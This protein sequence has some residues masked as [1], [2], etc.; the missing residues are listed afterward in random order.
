MDAAG[1]PALN[2]AT[3][4]STVNRAMPAISGTPMLAP[5]AGD[6]QAA[7]NGAELLNRPSTL[8]GDTNSTTFEKLRNR[9]LVSA[10]I[11]QAGSSSLGAAA[12]GY[13]A[14]QYGPESIP[15]Y[16]R[17]PG[18]MLAGALMGQRAG[19]YLGRVVG[20]IPG[21]SAAITGPTE[22]IMRRVSAGLA[23]P[24]EYQRLLSSQMLTGP[25]LTTPGFI[26]A[27][28]PA[29]ARAAIPMA[30]RGGGR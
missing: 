23:S 2:T 26:S 19:P 29:A 16:L 9:D 3:M 20:H 11:G 30:T 18:G 27:A 5:A 15:S 28:V 24:A 1:Q 10:I 14:G 4:A 12:G 22:D 13:A 8:R 6:I 21:A 7:G 25:D 17:I